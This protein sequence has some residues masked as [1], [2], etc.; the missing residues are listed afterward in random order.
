MNRLELVRQRQTQWARLES[1]LQ[2]TE[3]NRGVSALA[4]AEI[5]EFAEL[6]R[7]LASD[8]MRVRRDLLG[9]DLERHLD[10]LA[11]RAH[12]ALYA[13]SAVGARWRFRD[14]LFDF[15]GA[16][17]RNRRFFSI[18]CLLFFAPC[19]LG[20][21]AAY[22]DETYALA[23]MSEGQLA[24]M[25]EMHS[26]GHAAG[27]G[28][29]DDAAMTGFYINNNIGIAFRAFATGLLFGLGPVF[30]LV[31]NGLNIGV[32][33]GHLART[34]Y[35]EN[36]FSFGAAHS[37]WELVAI[38]IAGGAGLQ[39]GFS[40]VAT[41]GRTRIGSLTAHGLELLRQVA[42]AAAFLLLAAI[43]EGWFSPSALPAPA[44]Y[45]AGIVGWFAV[46]GIL[47]FAGRHRPTPEDALALVEDRR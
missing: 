25:E 27:R 41:H 7:G 42:G 14:L 6:Y 26:K 39:M 35:G 5:G 36:I 1:L 23:I 2:Q 28:S 40:L 19:F 10:S 33:F 8:L 17:R 30:F 34:G 20:G 47:V 29:D 46:A 45:A 22:A 43:L 18:A 13:R 37:A 9:A 3:K 38:V 4:P 12:N 15:P 32:V 21:F 44:K 31:F 16:V 24:S 11:S